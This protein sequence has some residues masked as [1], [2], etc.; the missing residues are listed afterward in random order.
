M[1][2]HTRAAAGTVDRLVAQQHEGHTPGT[3]A[4][5]RDRRRV[6]RDDRGSR[7]RS[8]VCG[9]RVPDHR[10]C[11]A[12]QRLHECVE[13]PVDQLDVEWCVTTRDQCD[14]LVGPGD[15]DTATRRFERADHGPPL[16]RCECA[17]R[18]RRAGMDNDV[19]A[20]WRSSRCV[21]EPQQPVVAGRQVVAHRAREREA[22]L[23]LVHVLVD[24]MPHVD[25]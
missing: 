7:R 9:T 1:C 19:F 5:G 8:Q 6:T 13:R 11:G 10:G 16:L 21:P 3:P 2:G 23:H 18:H 12:A 14:L 20:P 24:D 17:R 25:E 4:A 22:A 15:D